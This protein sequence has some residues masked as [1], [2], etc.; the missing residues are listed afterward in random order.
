MPWGLA[1]AA[2]GGDKRSL[3]GSR[4]SEMKAYVCSEPVWL[5]GRGL[6][7]RE[8]AQSIHAYD[9]TKITATVEIKEHA[10]KQCQP[11]HASAL[12]RSAAGSWCGSRKGSQTRARPVSTDFTFLRAV[13]K[14]EAA[15]CF[16][17]QLAG[18]HDQKT[19]PAAHRPREVWVLAP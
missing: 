10:A 14:P 6:Y 9:I 1:R 12:S 16:P 4:I 18:E 17:S 5:R 7:S 19:K 8:R 3:H 15:Q 13:A 11:N 2:D